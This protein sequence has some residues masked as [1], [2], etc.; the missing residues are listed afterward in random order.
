MCFL[1]NQHIAGT[2]MNNK[3]SFTTVLMLIILASILGGCATGK[4]TYT[5]STPTQS[6]FEALYTVKPGDRLTD[7]SR[8]LTGN[9]NHWQTI[10]TYNNIENP[11]LLSVGEIIAIPGSLLGDFFPDT[12]SAASSATALHNSKGS[13]TRPSLIPNTSAIALQR[14]MQLPGKVVEEVIVTSVN[15]NRSFKL[16]PFRTLNPV[17]TSASFTAGARIKVIGSYYPKGIYE[18]PANYA[19]LIMRVSPG[20]ILELELEVNDWY[21]IKTDKGIGYIRMDDST[22]LQD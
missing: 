9:Q 16:E 7:I 4:Q 5:T 20:T 1:V 12:V 21:K 10:A 15:R 3:P 22:R 19:P 18:Q 17:Q 6:D 13:A 14:P 2:K 8:K 11:D